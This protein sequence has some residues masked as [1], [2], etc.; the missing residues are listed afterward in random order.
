MS[1]T[2]MNP[3]QIVIDVTAQTLTAYSKDQKI[4]AF[5]CVTGDFKHPTPKG[6]FKVL[7][8]ELV[9]RSRKYDAQMNY[10]MQINHSGIYIHE[11]YNF[12]TNPQQQNP[13]ATILSD[14]TAGAMSRL[15]GWLPKIGELEVPVG[16][17]NLTGSHGCIRLAHSDAAKLFDWADLNIPVI[18]K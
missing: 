18:V 2:K 14:T 15:R 4:Y 7:K 17:I 16:N 13:F 3:K 11:S 8:K 9:R 12:S 10:A 6:N 5:H 1:V